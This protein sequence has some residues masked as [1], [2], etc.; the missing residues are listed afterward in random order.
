MLIFANFGQILVN[1]FT[2]P[3]NFRFLIK[4]ITNTVTYQL[5]NKCLFLSFTL[6]P[7]CCTFVPSNEN[8][9]CI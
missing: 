9:H 1:Y 6:R 4:I 2:L 5:L 3:I 7:H 8:N